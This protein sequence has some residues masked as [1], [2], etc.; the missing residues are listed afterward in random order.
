VLCGKF[1]FLL[2]NLRVIIFNLN[3]WLLQGYDKNLHR[4]I[5]NSTSCLSVKWGEMILKVEIR[6]IHPSLVT[7]WPVVVLL[8]IFVFCVRY[9]NAELSTLMIKYN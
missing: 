5:G 2:K 9:I 8:T 6:Y 3:K 7:C 4:R 1:F